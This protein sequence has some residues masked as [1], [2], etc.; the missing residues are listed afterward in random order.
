M[1]ELINRG[2]EKISPREVEDALLAHPSV[3]EAVAFGVP[4]ATL[5]ESVGAAI[6]LVPGAPVLDLAELRTF[7][8]ARLAPFKVPRTIVLVDEI[9]LG[10]TGK[11][12]RV[13]MARRLGID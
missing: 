3:A 1:K 4:H 6:R 2:G 5:G 10:A 13:G 7:V 8:R 11:P 12:Q 9:P